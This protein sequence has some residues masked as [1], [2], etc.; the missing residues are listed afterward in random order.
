MT[1]GYTARH[2]LRYACQ[3]YSWQLSIDRY[4]GRIEHMVRVAAAAGFQGLEPELVMLGDSWTVPGLADVL[5]RHGIALAALVLAQPWRTA[6]ETD[7]ER[8]AADVA[9][10]TAAALGAKLV[11]VPL[12]GPDRSDLFERQ[13]ATIACMDAVAR[14]AADA[15]VSST[16]HPNSPPGSLFRTAG[17]Y[18]VMAELL[19]ERIGYTP[20]VGHIA[21]GGMDPLDVVRHWGARVDH[22][23]VKD[24]AADGT[25]APTGAGVVDIAGVLDQL[26][27]TGYAGWVTFED[28]SPQAE[29]DPDGAVVRNAAWIRDWEER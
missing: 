8:A 2:T 27:S 23:H 1:E 29:S 17:D 18:A 7:A 19:P 11:L 5:R 21:K 25:W 15:G 16:F 4:A 10:S 26:R 3:T 12:P 22:V 13:R 24:L 20:D 14:R 28:E 6:T 9:V